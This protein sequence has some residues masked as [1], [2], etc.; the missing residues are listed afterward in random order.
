MQPNGDPL[1]FGPPRPR[2][3][4]LP[5][6]SRQAAPFPD[7]SK[8][9]Y[10]ATFGRGRCHRLELILRC[11]FSELSSESQD[12]ATCRR[13]FPARHFVNAL[14]SASAV[15]KPHFFLDMALVIV[16]KSS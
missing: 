13:I 1:G 6:D 8:S 11:G 5:L 2:S 15:L 7:L 14:Y 9:R 3:P 16:E 4:R 10:P 12:A